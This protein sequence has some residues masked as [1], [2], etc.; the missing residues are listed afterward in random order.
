MEGRIRFGH[1]MTFGTSLAFGSIP[2]ISFGYDDRSTQSHL[3][4]YP[5]PSAIPSR[6]SNGSVAAE[7]TGPE[8]EDRPEYS[9][10]IAYLLQALGEQ[11]AFVESVS[12]PAME[13]GPSES[14]VSHVYDASLQTHKADDK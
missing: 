12:P 9:L 11:L 8:L 1:L 14:S 6:P 13:N 7:M 10:N 5:L 2:P 3:S 4:N